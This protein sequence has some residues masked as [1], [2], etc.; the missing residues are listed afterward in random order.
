VS[1]LR[2]LVLLLLGRLLLCRRGETGKSG[3][4]HRDH[5]GCFHE[6]VLHWFSILVGRSVHG[7][8]KLLALM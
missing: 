2:L 8:K 6:S 7:A 3:K 5:C 4:R 1:L